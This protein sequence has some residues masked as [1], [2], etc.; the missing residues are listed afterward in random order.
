[1]AEWT[2]LLET[3]NEKHA[4]AFADCNQTP[5]DLRMGWSGRVP[6]PRQ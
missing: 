6:L 4:I 2:L 1:M 3:K 5:D